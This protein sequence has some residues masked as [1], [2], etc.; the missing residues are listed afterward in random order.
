VIYNSKEWVPLQMRRYCKNSLPEY[1]DFPA[2]WRIIR[3]VLN[4]S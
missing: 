1:Q 3:S 2:A 4:K